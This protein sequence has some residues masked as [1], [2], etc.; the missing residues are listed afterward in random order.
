MCKKIKSPLECEKC[1]RV[2]ASSGGLSKHRLRCEEVADVAKTAEGSAGATFVNNNMTNC[3]NTTNSHNT[4]YNVTQNNVINVNSFG[5]ENKDYIAIEFVRFCLNMGGHG[6]SPMID[7]I[8]FDPEHPENHN[9]HLESFKNSLVKVVRD[10]KHELASLLNTVDTM[11]SRAASL[12]VTTMSKE[13]LDLMKSEA[14]ASD[15]MNNVSSIQNIKP[16][17]KKRIRDHTKSRL[18]HRRESLQRLQ[19]L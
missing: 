15:T 14:T 4:T 1:H 17:M 2:F 8:Y 18:A 5:Q 3:H 16:E 9:V 11:M 7:K 12:I 10:N 19:R 6:I 13:I